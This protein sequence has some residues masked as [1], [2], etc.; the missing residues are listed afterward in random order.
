YAP[1]GDGRLVV[2]HGTDT[3]VLGVLDPATGELTDLDLPYTL[4]GSVGVDGD[5][6]LTT[7]ASPVEPPVVLAV[8]LTTGA[9]TV[10]RRSMA[11]PPD[12]AYLPQPRSIVVAGPGERDV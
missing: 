8:D 6:V 7:A 10:L 4:F 9:G 3:L 5:T 11:E 2:R 12:P 1:V